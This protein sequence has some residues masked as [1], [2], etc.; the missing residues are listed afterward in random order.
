MTKIC[1]NCSMEVEDSANFCP[2]CKGQTFRKKNEVTVSDNSMVHRLFY[3][4]YGGRYVVARAK[5]AAAFVGVFFILALIETGNVIGFVI[6]GVIAVILTYLIGLGIHKI[7][8]RPPQAKLDNSDYGLAEDL[9]HFFCYWQNNAGQYVI[10][11]TKVISLI[12]F[13]FFFIYGMTLSVPPLGPAAASVFA[14]LFVI[15][16][17]VI[18]YLIHRF[19]NPDPQPK[20]ETRQAPKPKVEHKVAQ[21]NKGRVIPE[22]M[23]YVRQIDELNS[24]FIKKEKS[25]REIIEKRFEPPQLTYTRFISGVDKSKEL[26]NK[27]LES[28]WNMIS[29]ADSYSPRIASEIESKIDVLKAIVEKMDGLLNELVMNE[30]ISKKEDVDNLMGEMDSL[31]D[32]VRDYE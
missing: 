8:A 2:G 13:I 15:P 24:K 4:N 22:Y 11:K 14:I 16:A 3:W 19:T 27:N 29:I 25:T 7:T 21:I 28:A 12:I 32:S 23:D 17:Y 9:K 1:S 26:F 6:L 20:I 18:G 5:I 31:I 10:S 30:D